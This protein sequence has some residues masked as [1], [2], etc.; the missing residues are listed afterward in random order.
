[1]KSI[2]KLLGA[3]LPLC[4]LAACGAG[5]GGSSVS[6]SAP[7]SVSHPPTP[8][9]STTQSGA[10][11][12]AESATQGSSMET[13]GSVSGELPAS[14]LGYEAY[15]SEEREFWPDS[16]PTDDPNVW[17]FF[18]ADGTL[19]WHNNLIGNGSLVANN[20]TDY[21]VGSEVVTYIVGGTQLYATAIDNSWNQFVHESQLPFERVVSN[22]ELVFFLAGGIVY[23][24][25]VESGITDAFHALDATALNFMPYSNFSIFWEEI[26]RETEVGQTFTDFR[27]YS[28]LGTPMPTPQEL[29][30]RWGVFLKENNA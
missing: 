15:Y 30:T 22:A 13:S 12:E 10:S 17:S 8:P 19:Y 4:L 26:V 6:G 16:Q 20:V 7:G 1:M 27:W 9:S 21:L 24:H 3:L 23:R 29:M 11:S 28:E 5:P 14:E 25:H 2:A 18:D